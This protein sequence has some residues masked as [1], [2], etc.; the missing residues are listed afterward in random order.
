MALVI[1]AS[2]TLGWYFPDETNPTAEAVR[3]RFATDS[4][5]APG[6]WWYEIRNALIAGER[7]G[8]IDAARPPRSW[9]SS[10]PCRS[11]STANLT[12]AQSSPWRARTD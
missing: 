8:R 3:R 1:D 5:V 10:T 11:T 12:A 6:L 9:H 2:V 7:R 4:A